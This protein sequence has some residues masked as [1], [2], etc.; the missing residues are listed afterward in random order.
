MADA[1]ADLDYGTADMARAILRCMHDRHLGM[2]PILAADLA[3]LVSEPRSHARAESPWAKIFERLSTELKPPMARKTPW[4]MNGRQR[5]GLLLSASPLFSV[6]G[7][8]QPILTLAIQQL[9]RNILFCEDTPG[10]E[11]D[12]GGYLDYEEALSQV[13]DEL[14]LSEKPKMES[15]WRERAL[16]LAGLSREALPGK[17]IS[18]HI[19]QLDSTL[20]S[21][22]ENARPNVVLPD[23]P[24][25]QPQLK[26]ANKTLSRLHKLKEGGV[27]GIRISRRP[28]DISGMLF[29]E[30]VRPKP[31][32]AERLLNSGFMVVRREPQFE[33]LRD[34]MV[35]ALV[36]GELTNAVHQPI[37]KLAF[38]ELSLRLGFM[39]CRHRLNHTAFRWVEGHR[40]AGIRDLS[41]QLDALPSAEG[42]L[43]GH[44]PDAHFRHHFLASL[45]W[46]PKFADQQAPYQRDHRGAYAALRERSEGR[47]FWLRRA[48]RG[49]P[50][51]KQEPPVISANRFSYVHVL[52]IVPEDYRYR[53]RTMN[54]SHVRSVLGLGEGQRE[55]V[56]LTVVPKHVS[57]VTGWRY[58]TGQGDGGK[59]MMPEAD[60]GNVVAMAGRLASLWLE[61]LLR[62]IWRG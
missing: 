24:S 2:T 61:T 56:S 32:Q 45:G 41:F 36:P 26:P 48:W 21:L 53:E 44:Q 59:S 8:A 33:A 5:V 9:G 35:V 20:F 49:L 31:L 46:L 10:A 15:F 42:S 55:K 14:A 7:V 62:E 39:L 18:N 38:Y 25:H 1:V 6:L 30:Y 17:A 58:L 11:A 50:Q 60:A 57:D 34:V 37:L 12:H 52:A 43:L 3:V 13:F 16:S 23:P 4:R 22:L 51:S 27:D 19:P 54:L 28:E 47:V 29:S 40:L